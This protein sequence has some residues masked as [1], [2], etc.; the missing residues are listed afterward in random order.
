MDDLEEDVGVHVEFGDAV[1]ERRD[2]RVDLS[3]RRRPS[4]HVL[5]HLRSCGSSESHDGDLGEVDTEVT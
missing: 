5:L 2:Q 1:G 4:L 3:E